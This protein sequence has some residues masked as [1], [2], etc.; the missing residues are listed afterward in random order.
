MIEQSGANWEMDSRTMDAYGRWSAVI[1]SNLNDFIE[2]VAPGCLNMINT[3]NA[4]PITA[5][6]PSEL[7]NFRRDSGNIV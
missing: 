4:E 6:F 7:I 1:S 2:V 5:M 3:A